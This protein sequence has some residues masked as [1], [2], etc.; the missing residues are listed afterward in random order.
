[1]SY[2]EIK[3]D[4]PETEVLSAD[5]R[6]IAQLLR[7]LRTVEAPKNFGMLFKARLANAA[8][9]SH[10][11]SG[12]LPVLRF[13]AP[14]GI[15]LLL[16]A[17][18]FLNEAYTVEN[19]SVPSVADS[20]KFSDPI[21]NLSRVPTTGDDIP[22]AV[23]RN[24]N[25]PIDSPDAEKIYE[26]VAASKN[27]PRLVIE[28]RNTTVKRNNGGSVDRTQGVKN[29]ILPRGLN[30]QIVDPKEKPRGFDNAGRFTAKEVLTAIGIDAE[31]DG[32]AW[33]VKSV[34]KDS[35]AENSGIKAADTIEAIDD[36]K[37]DGKS[38]FTGSFSGKTL[39]VLRDS[40]KLE[41]NL[42]DE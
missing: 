40:K 21:E 14:L 3:H 24:E 30:P 34:T 29:T 15:I 8:P 10:K 6:Q 33:K 41:I 28:K 19:Q 1:M 39:S 11:T 42:Q 5:D 16:G 36:R 35:P 17:V 23:V 22:P 31:F 38:V 26:V 13:A 4:V 9:N 7:N 18:F 32:N 20:F 27:K 37:I 2:E 12:F 25:A